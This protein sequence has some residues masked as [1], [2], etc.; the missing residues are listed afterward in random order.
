MSR[1]LLALL[2]LIALTASTAITSAADLRIETRVYGPDS[3]TPLHEGVTL[4]EGGMVF[5]FRDRGEKVTI[6]R[7]ATAGKPGRFVLLDTKRRVR[8]ELTTDRIDAVMTKLRDWADKQ[9]NDY[10][11]FTAE[12]RFE[13]SHDEELGQLKLESD[14][15]SYRVVTIPIDHVDMKLAVREFLDSYAGL[16]TLLQGGLPPQPRLKL[17]EAL[18]RHG[19]MPIEVHRYAGRISDSSDADVWADHL[20]AW[21]LSKQDRQ[22]IEVA[23]DHMASFEQVSNE[24]FQHGK[25]L[26]AADR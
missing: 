1:R 24:A 19:A 8:T 6:F 4:F 23:I 9:S 20:V 13:E 2:L 3:E 25:E 12:P 10:V 15:L 26:A 16:Q 22:R 11:R 5:D 18:F 14:H 7:A 21:V 17:N